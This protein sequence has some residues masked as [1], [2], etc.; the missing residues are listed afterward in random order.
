[1]MSCHFVVAPV[2]CLTSHFLLLSTGKVY[3]E[4]SVPQAPSSP[5]RRSLLLAGGGSCCR[6]VS[7]EV[8]NMTASP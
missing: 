2:A 7:E 4:G 8:R 5:A 3:T 1:M 6:V